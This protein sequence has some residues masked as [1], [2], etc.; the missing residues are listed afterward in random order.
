MEK[1]AVHPYI[2]IAFGIL[3][4]AFSAVFVK[5]ASA[6]AGVTA[7]Y[8]MFFSAVIMLPVFI[9][10]YRNECRKMKRKDWLLCAAAGVLLAAHFVLWFESLHYTSVASSTLLVAL[11][12]IFALAGTAVLFNEA[13]TGKMIAAVFIALAGSVM[14]GWQDLQISGTALF[15]DALALIACVF[16][17]AYLLIGQDVRQRV[18]LITYT[19]IV[20]SASTAALFI[21]VLI[22]HEPFT[23]YP[24]SDWLWFLALALLPNLLGHTLFNWAV[25]WVSTNIISIAS[26]FEPVLAA[27]AAYFIL[28]EKLYAIQ[29]AGG[30]VVL[31][32]ILLFIADPEWIKK[33]F[34]YKK[35]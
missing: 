29:I 21:Y 22:I 13:V 4:V 8:R 35:A 11:Q 31:A 15:G 3:T 34:F 26:L 2:P 32:G 24:S 12:P 30:I 1:P 17:T 23:G 7:F 19:F 20:Y 6:D 14:I 18:S 5:L 10:F 16:V 25:R 28:D 33:K 9:L 27:A